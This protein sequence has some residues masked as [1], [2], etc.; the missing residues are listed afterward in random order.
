MSIA[1]LPPG[2]P[3]I[4]ASRIAITFHSDITS[5]LAFVGMAMQM[6][7][8]KIIP[9]IISELFLRLISFA[10]KNLF[11]PDRILSEEKGEKR[12]PSRGDRINLR[13]CRSTGCAETFVRPL[14]RSEERRVG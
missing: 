4:P 6:A 7:T 11:I 2:L 8:V 3:A 5:A 13:L 10:S 14:V 12:L 9:I 1:A